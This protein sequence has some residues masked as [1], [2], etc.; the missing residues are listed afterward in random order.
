[1]MEERRSDPEALLAWV[2]SED[3]RE[4]R[5]KLVVKH[6]YHMEVVENDLRLRQVCRHRSQ[7]CRGHV[8]GDRLYQGSAPPL[9]TYAPWLWR[10]RQWL[11]A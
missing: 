5:G 10:F 11:S 3:E 8:N 1:M 4:H 2:K 7:I 9:N 6:F